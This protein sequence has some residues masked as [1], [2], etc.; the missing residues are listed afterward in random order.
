MSH[1]LA[2]RPCANPCTSHGSAHAHALARASWFIKSMSHMVW[3]LTHMS[4]NPNSM[5]Y[6]VW[7]HTCVSCPCDPYTSLLTH[8]LTYARVTYLYDPKS[9]PMELHGPPHEFSYGCVAH[10]TCAHTCVVACVLST[11]P[12]FTEKK[13]NKRKGFGAHQ[14]YNVVE[15]PNAN[16]MPKISSEHPIH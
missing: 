8:G 3:T 15:A 2:A 5:S 7:I 11:A 10:T 12:F 9:E 6:I 16:S 4:T 14:L 1:G 13:C